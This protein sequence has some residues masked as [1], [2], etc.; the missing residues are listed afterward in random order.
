MPSFLPPSLSPPA[1]RSGL[2]DL[3][4]VTSEDAGP[5]DGGAPPG[6]PVDSGP[7]PCEPAT[8]VVT[9]ASR[10][11]G[12]WFA[13]L[14]VDATNVYWLEHGDDESGPGQLLRVSKCGGP[15][16][17][18]TSTPNYPAGLAVDA[19][20]AYWSNQSSDLTGSVLRVPLSGGGE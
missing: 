13:S 5:P 12:T 8:G 18:I 17:T 4:G 6:I 1:A 9:L 20:N 16:V 19:T 7:A 11:L 2:D 14:A 10:P 3:L 15:V